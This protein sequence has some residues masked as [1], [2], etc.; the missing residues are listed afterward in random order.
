MATSFLREDIAALW[1]DKDPL[2]EAQALQGE[3]YRAVARRR[4]MRVELASRHFFVKVH[5]GVGWPEIFKNWL[6][7]KRPVV[8]ARNEFEACRHLERMNITAPKVAAYGE[9]ADGAA[10]RF[11]FVLCDA[12]EGYEDLE[13]KTNRWFDVAPTPLEVRH[14]VMAVA[15]FARRFHE[16]GVVHRD[17]Y[18]CHLL[19]KLDDA[20]APLGV[21]DLHRAVIFPQLPTKWRLRDLAALLYSSLDLPISRRAWLRFVRVYTGKPLRQTFAEDGEF[22]RAVYRRACVLYEKGRRKGLVRGHFQR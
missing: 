5:Y 10:S 17:F 15:S 16:A 8:G 3:V 12:L 21:L 1:A 9:S 20:T 18:L 19:A 13:I 2:V 6:T 22:W 11:S 7:L 14:L 4:T